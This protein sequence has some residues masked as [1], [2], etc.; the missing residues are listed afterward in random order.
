MVDIL[1]AVALGLMA[2]F[3]AYMGVHMTLTPPK[4]NKG[5]TLYR[6]AFIA[7]ALA[8]V[9]LGG[10]QAKRTTGAQ[11]ETT[12]RLKE[13]ERHSAENRKLAEENKTLT[14]AL[15]SRPIEVNVP[16]A[17]WDEAKYPVTFTQRQTSATKDNCELRVILRT[18][19]VLRAP[20]LT[21]TFDGPVEWFDWEGH[22]TMVEPETRPRILSNNRVVEQYWGWGTWHPDNPQAFVIHSKMPA[23]LKS[24]RYRE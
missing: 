1:L 24:V 18:S 23:S 5:K 12:E 11:A 4:D 19:R 13:I 21:F 3:M 10:L 8:S 7:C 16:P 9:A 22:A 17:R 15:G 6:L 2:A 20:V 14:I